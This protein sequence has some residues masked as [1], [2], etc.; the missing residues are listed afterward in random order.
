MTATFVTAQE[1]ADSRPYMSPVSQWVRPDQ[2]RGIVVM[3]GE[4]VVASALL[5]RVL[6]VEDVFVR[7]DRRTNPAVGRHLLRL[8]QQ[9]AA[10]LN[11]SYVVSS[12]VTPEAV[13]LLAHRSMHSE[14]MP[15]PQVVYRMSPRGFHAE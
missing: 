11:A 8:I 2:S 13:Q 4:A 5:Y 9:G 14:L 6:Y 12:A 3:D 1:I 7:E 10:S 15:G